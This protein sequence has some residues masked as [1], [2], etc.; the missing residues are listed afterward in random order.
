MRELVAAAQAQ[1]WRVDATGKHINL[2]PPNQAK[3]IW[4]PHD[5]KKRIND[6][7]KAARRCG[8]AI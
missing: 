4:L 8:L 1:G 2:Y 6:Q 7:A 3:P 5:A